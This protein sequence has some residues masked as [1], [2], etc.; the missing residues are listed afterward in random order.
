MEGPPLVLCAQAALQ[1]DFLEVL[2]E[3][4]DLAPLHRLP[5]EVGQ[6]AQDSLG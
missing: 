4:A 6:V 3:H 5:L 2:D 1:P